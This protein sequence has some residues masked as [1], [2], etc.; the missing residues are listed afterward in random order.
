MTEEFKLKRESPESIE[1]GDIQKGVL[2][3][4]RKIGGYLVEVLYVGPGAIV[5]KR[6]CKKDWEIRYFIKD[7]CMD[8]TDRGE[9]QVR[10]VN[11]T[12]QPIYAICIRGNNQK[13]TEQELKKLLD[14]YKDEL[15]SMKIALQE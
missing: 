3:D 1:R 15:E 2:A 9:E 5:A 12:G 7:K 14:S 11:T 13:P 10:F 6:Q 4:E 8:V